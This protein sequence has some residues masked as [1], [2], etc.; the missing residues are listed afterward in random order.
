[1][2]IFHKPR[3]NCVGES[4]F[5]CFLR[6]HFPKANYVEESYPIQAEY[7][8]N[9]VNTQLLIAA[10]EQDHYLPVAAKEN[11]LGILTNECPPNIKVALNPNSISFDIVRSYAVEQ[12]FDKTKE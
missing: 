1:M 8:E 10:L 3:A 12:I 2:R 9:S 4:L 5:V 11:C 6:K 7:L